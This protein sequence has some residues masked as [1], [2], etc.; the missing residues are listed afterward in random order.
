MPIEWTTFADEQAVQF[1]TAPLNSDLTVAG[2]GHVDL[3][4]LPGSDDTSVQATLTE[5]RADGTEVR[6][7]SGWHRPQHRVEDPTRSDEL[8]VDYTFAP[9]DRSPLAVGEPVHFRL[10]FMPLAHRFRAGT[11]IRV[12]VSTPGRDTPLWCFDNPITPGAIH[13]VRV[14]GEQASSLV[15]PVWD[16]PD[17]VLDEAHVEPPGADALRGQPARPALPIRNV[18]ADS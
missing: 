9:E 12:S 6:V 13:T 4:M 2:Q 5:I 11:R 1:E 8:R 16:D 18:P 14:G 7:Q 17:H 3:W 10:P 15:L